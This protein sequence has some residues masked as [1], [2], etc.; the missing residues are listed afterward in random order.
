MKY[1]S[2]RGKWVGLVTKS[3]EMLLWS[4]GGSLTSIEQLEIPKSE[5]SYWAPEAITFH[6]LNDGHFF[7]FYHNWPDTG[8]LIQEFVGGKYHTSYRTDWSDLK[9][10]PG[11]KNLD[12]RIVRVLSNGLCSIGWD[13]SLRYCK[14]SSEVKTFNMY[15]CEFGAMPHPSPTIPRSLEDKARGM[16]KQDEPFELE[17]S[18]EHPGV[19]ELCA[20]T[21]YHEDFEVLFGDYG[22]V[23][24]SFDDDIELPVAGSLSDATIERS[25][26]DRPLP[27]NRRPIHQS[28]R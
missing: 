27:L 15:T 7:I 14:A 1:L 2:A 6:P 12:L 4:V 22:Y 26:T 24:W 11:M 13:V 9:D 25:S 28:T 17:F 20:S 5:G 23:V 19:V 18:L 16:V 21:F 10:S 3:N 8:M